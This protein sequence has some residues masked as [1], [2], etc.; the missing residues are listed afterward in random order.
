[1]AILE[2][3]L[4][5]HRRGWCIIPIRAGTKKPAI[6]EW[7][8][9]QSQP[10]SLEDI[11]GWFGSD[12]H[13]ALAVVLG[14]VSGDLVCRDFDKLDSYSTWSA[15][16][17]QLAATLPTV[18]TSR[19]HHVYFRAVTDVLRRCS[20]T[21]SV[22][23]KLDDG[24]MRG[25][26]AYVVLP[27]SP[28]PNGGQYR[29][30]IPLSEGDIPMLDPVPAGLVPDPD[31]R[32]RE[33]RVDRGLQSDTE[34]I[35]SVH[36]VDSVRSVYSVNSVVSDNS[37]HSAN[38]VLSVAYTDEFPE[39][40]QRAILESLPESVGQRNGM[41]LRLARA[42]KALPSLSDAPIKALKP[43]VRRWHELAKPVIG[44]KPFEES[45]FDFGHAWP[46]VKFPL[47]TEPMALI[48]ERAG[49]TDLPP[50]AL[51]YEQP[52]LQLLVALCRELQRE[53]GDGPFYLSCRTAGRLLGVH[54][55]TASAWLAGLAIDGVVKVIVRG[56]QKSM[57]ASRYRYLG[58]LRPVCCQN[59]NHRVS[60]GRNGQEA[61]KARFESPDQQPTPAAG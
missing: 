40:V 16:H 5:Y 14:P 1:M 38:S 50:E 24:E 42:L 55:K 34:A 37:V 23:F 33:D 13:T 28:H 54:Y 6:S 36:S 59:G 44:T 7:K 48:F 27:P 45:W 17:P 3:A 43:V 32:H 31:V 12:A 18:S 20:P 61:L 39:P 60:S 22:T 10:P 52:A 29:W 11:Q 8:P 19:G 15:G 46:R 2:A 57:R 4:S 49:R 30:L 56:G 26:G 53:A 51:E 9:F 21:G 35:G 25:L 58:E 47:G 41:L